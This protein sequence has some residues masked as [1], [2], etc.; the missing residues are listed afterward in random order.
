M[1]SLVV[2]VPVDAE[3]LAASEGSFSADSSAVALVDADEQRILASNEPSADSG[4]P[5]E[6]VGR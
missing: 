1:G 5:A 4:H 3:I 2:L 6:R